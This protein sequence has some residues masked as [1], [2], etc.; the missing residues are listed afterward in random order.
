MFHAPGPP[1]RAHHPITGQSRKRT[2]RLISTFL[3]WGRSRDCVGMAHCGLFAFG[4]TN[5]KAAA[6][7][8]ALFVVR[9]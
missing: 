5:P 6:A 1:V 3:Q 2:R 4:P 7:A 8:T 9:R